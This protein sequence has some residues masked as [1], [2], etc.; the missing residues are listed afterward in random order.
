MTEKEINKKYNN[1]FIK[2]RSEFKT[3]IKTDVETNAEW[4]ELEEEKDD[5]LEV[6]GILSEKRSII[7]NKEIFAEANQEEKINMIAERM[8]L[9]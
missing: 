2:L 5:A 8:N 7:R 6:I 4:K 1:K 9:K 3:G